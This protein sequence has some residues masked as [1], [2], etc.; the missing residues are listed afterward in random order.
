MQANDNIIRHFELMTNRFRLAQKFAGAQFEKQLCNFAFSPDNQYLLSPSE[1]GK[2]YLWDLRY[3]NSIP[4]D[5]LNLDIK[6]PLI[7]CDWH[8]KYNLVAFGGFV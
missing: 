4:V 3:G 5:H 1:S 2:P 7:T 8:P 6:G